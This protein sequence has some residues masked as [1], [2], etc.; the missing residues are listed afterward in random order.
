METKILNVN[1]MTCTHCEKAVTKALTT[2]EG[3]KNVHVSLPGKTV[4]I[5]FEPEKITLDEL[6]YAIEDQGYDIV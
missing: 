6:K 2:L 1:G 3:V 5:Q 4:A